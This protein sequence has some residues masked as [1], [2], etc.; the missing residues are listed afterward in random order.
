MAAYSL[1]LDFDQ[2]QQGVRNGAP[3]QYGWLGAFGIMV[4]VVWLYVEILRILA[5][6]ARQQLTPA[7]SAHERPSGS[8]GGRS[9][10]PRPAACTDR[11]SR[12]HA[13]DGCSARR[14][15]E[16][17]IRHEPA[18]LLWAERVGGRGIRVLS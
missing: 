6:A 9:L 3:R 18:V 14:V 2:I 1:V 15:G 4:T 17:P 13:G 10:S 8:P 16:S 7:H 12:R 5:I 11:R